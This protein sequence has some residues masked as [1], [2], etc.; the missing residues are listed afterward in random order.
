MDFITC[1]NVFVKAAE[2]GSFSL[3]ATTCNM[4][5]P[6]VSRHI[7]KLEDEL[8]TSLFHRTTRKIELTDAGKIFYEKSINILNYIRDA[9]QITSNI[10]DDVAGHLRISFQE[11]FYNKYIRGIIP[12]FMDK[13]PR[14]SIHI[15]TYIKYDTALKHDTDLKII[16]RFP[17]HHIGYIKKIT[18]NNYI[19]CA[20]PDYFRSQSHPKDPGDL[21]N[22][23]CITHSQD[24]KEKWS[25]SSAR[26]S[27]NEEVEVSGKFS[28][29]D[30]LAILEI[31][32]QNIGIARLPN[33]LVAPLV[34]R[35]QLITT[36]PMYDTTPENSG[37]YIV[38]KDKSEASSKTRVFIEFIEKYLGKPPIWERS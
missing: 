33:W 12:D 34:H 27:V 18:T 22:H 28:S 4:N 8:G 6:S 24:G 29:N 31:V 36:L 17:D 32:F 19:I 16:L 25:F 7:K 13:Y 5:K 1:T 23:N 35:G 9:K 10:S 37:I 14:I 15:E 26:S 11:H 38:S 2:L 3:A 30:M 21:I 20:S